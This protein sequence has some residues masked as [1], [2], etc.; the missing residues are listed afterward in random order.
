MMMRTSSSLKKGKTKK[1]TKQCQ[2]TPTKI[3][4]L[5]K[6][7]AGLENK[8]R[9]TT[10]TEA[11]ALVHQ[12]RCVKVVEHMCCGKCGEGYNPATK[13]KT[14]GKTN[15]LLHCFNP[16]PTVSSFLFLPLLICH[17]LSLHFAHWCTPGFS[18]SCLSSL[19]SPG[20]KGG[21]GRPS[22]PHNSSSQY[23]PDDQNLWM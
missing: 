2:E 21:G 5:K 23:C 16:S 4:T 10:E 19:Q 11:C 22:K 9:S 3:R 6:I 1:K 8:S 18:S 14:H 7:P 12:H 13:H 20:E 17:S 15:Q